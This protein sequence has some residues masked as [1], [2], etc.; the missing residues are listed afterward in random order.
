MS[1]K[2]Q[3]VLAKNGLGS[4]REIER[5]ISEGRIKVDGVVAH[6]GARLDVASK[7][8]LDDKPVRLNNIAVDDT[9]LLYHKPEGELC[10]RHDPDG[11]PDVFS[12]IPHPKKGRFISV[13]RLDLNTSGLLLFTTNG[14]LAHR[15]MHPSYG[16]ERE[17][18]VRVLGV[19]SDIQ[20]DQLQSGVLIDGLMAKFTRIEQLHGAGANVW[21]RVVILEGRQ[22]E[23]RRLWEAVGL[24]VSRLIRIRFGPI[25]LPKG[26]QKGQFVYLSPKEVELLKKSVNLT[27][28]SS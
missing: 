8:L 21:Y 18:A 23:V 26:L 2:I 7:V 1:E 24:T 25:Q 11:R 27:E 28:V 12:A 22:R 5:W 10:T 20:L 3:K 6:L 17:Y 13:G 19:A 4:R 15:L 14:E 9:V 16:I